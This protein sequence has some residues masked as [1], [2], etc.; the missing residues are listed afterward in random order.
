MQATRFAVLGS[1]T[2]PRRLAEW[3]VVALALIIALIG[4]VLLTGGV[5]LIV[6]GG[7]WYYALAGAGLVAS[8]LLLAWRSRLGAWIYY[9]VFA[10]TLVWALFESGLSGWPLLP[11]LGGPLVILLAV[12]A[13]ARILKGP[14]PKAFQVWSVVATA[15]LLA[16]GSVS[17]YL[18]N[19]SPVVEARLPVDG[20]DPG[21]TGAAGA[22]W[23]V[24]AGSEDAAKFSTLTE[25][26]RANVDQLRRAWV[27]RT[28]DIPEERWGAE[29]TPIKIGDSMYLCTARNIIIALDPATGDERW[30]YDPQIDDEDIPYTAACRGVTYHALPE[31]PVSGN[32][33]TRIVEGTLDG[34]LVAVDASTGEPCDGFGNGG[35]VDIKRGMGD[36]SPGMVSITSPPV[37]VRGVIVTGHQVLDG[38]KRM[39]PS[40]VIQGFDLITGDLRWAWDM[41]RPDITGLPPEGQTYTHG[42]PNMWTIA[43]GDEELGLVYLPMG[44]SAVDYW[45]SMRRPEEDL[46]STSLVALDVSTGRPAWR[47]QTVHVDV[48][49]Y[50]LGSQPT[51]VNWHIGEDFTPAL[52]LASKQ[53]DIYILDRR[54]GLPLTGVEERGVPQGGVEPERRS[55]TQPFSTFHTLAKRQLKESD[56]WGMSPIDQM[57]C[58]IQFR[59]AAYQGPYTPP[60]VDRRWIQYPGYNGGS[61]W[62]GVA[63]DP[64]RRLIIANYNDTPNYNR[65][66]PR[67]E[68]DR[69]GWAPRDQS[70]GGNMGG[71]EGAGDPQAGTPFAIDVN[72]GWRMEGTGLLCKQPPYGGIRAIDLTSGQTV[73]DRPLGQARRNGPWGVPSMLPLTIGTPNNGGPAVTASGLV[74]IAAATDDL[75]RAID[76]GTGETLWTDALPAG[77]QANPMIYEAG[78]KQYVVIMAGGHHF[79]ETPAGDYVIAYALP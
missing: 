11:R 67:E 69:L 68:A 74:F 8:A 31:P 62:G 44:N 63:V 16:V 40:G 19:R 29:T 9:A 55:P 38:Q 56:M 15:A 71:H 76:A 13:A 70:R 65:L 42:T 46:H 24:Y 23:P 26:T 3:A 14:S 39:A 33:A 54:T 52:V 27:Y 77:G 79:M 49:D 66:V 45:S 72:A 10:G 53:G 58:R 17:I 21:R 25:I 7:S 6:L 28:G 51:L 78:G 4:V 43:T 59:Q 47:F 36:V 12:V 64:L 60:T 30:R 57:L 32:C 2:R 41:V 61:D 73:W 5:W 50:D 22:D 35:Q 20:I 18:A 37:I 1:W 48:W 75:L 34:R